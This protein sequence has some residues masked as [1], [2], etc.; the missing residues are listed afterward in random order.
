M[1]YLLSWD[2]MGLGIGL[3]YYF[4]SIKRYKI[5]SIVILTNKGRFD[6]DFPPNIFDIIV[7]RIAVTAVI[8]IIGIY[9]FILHTQRVVI[10]YIVRI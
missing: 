9:F 1:W 4:F 8:M 3:A 7:T 5:G 10:T 6:S 2:L